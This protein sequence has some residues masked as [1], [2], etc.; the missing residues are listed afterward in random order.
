MASQLLTILSI[1]VGVA[2]ITAAMVGPLYLLTI[3]MLRDMGEADKERT[4][5]LERQEKLGET[6]ESTSKD[7][8]EIRNTVEAH[9][10][11]NEN[12]A[13]HLHELLVGEREPGEYDNGDIPHGIEDCPFPETCPWH[14]P[15]GE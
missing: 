12:L 14:E 7:V 15:D 2:A 10:I 6:V 4:A 1:I 9:A 3:R 11:R 8:H 13:E 5:I